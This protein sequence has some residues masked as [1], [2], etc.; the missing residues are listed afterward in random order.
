MHDDNFSSAMT[1]EQGAA[2]QT[3]Q[4]GTMGGRRYKMEE[5]VLAHSDIVV[6]GLLY[7]IYKKQ[8]NNN[9]RYCSNA[10]LECHS[11]SL[12]SISQRRRAHA[13]KMAA[14]PHDA[15][16]RVSP[17]KFNAGGDSQASRSHLYPL[18]AGRLYFGVGI[19]PCLQLSSGGMASF[20]TQLLPPAHLIAGLTWLNLNF[21]CSSNK[22]LAA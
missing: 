2:A 3:N 19:Y 15:A 17:V 8:N 11:V 14:L 16:T 12:W 20:A 18:Q 9:K 10:C 1:R 7:K 13:G 4:P 6:G 21:C 22:T 5:Q